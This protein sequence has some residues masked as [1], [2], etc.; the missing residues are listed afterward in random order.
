MDN[1]DDAGMPQTNKAS[2][3]F[4]LEK[5]PARRS[6]ILITAGLNNSF[7]LEEKLS[8]LLVSKDQG[9]LNTF[10]PKAVWAFCDAC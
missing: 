1:M 10:E 2:A 5:E 4:S 3:G 9:C 7:N 6:H 8:M